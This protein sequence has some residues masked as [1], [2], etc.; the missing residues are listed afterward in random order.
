M[1]KIKDIKERLKKEIEPNRKV[2]ITVYVVLRFLV[3]VCMV[4]QSMR[5]N[6]HNVSLF[7]QLSLH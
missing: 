5:G 7:T 3:I 6:W 4:D 2:T 1:G